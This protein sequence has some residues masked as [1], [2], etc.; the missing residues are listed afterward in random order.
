MLIKIYQ[1]EDI[2]VDTDIFDNT[3]SIKNKIALKLDTLPKYIF[4]HGTK[5]LNLKDIINKDDVKEIAVLLSNKDG[6]DFEKGLNDSFLFLEN[7]DLNSDYESGYLYLSSIREKV[8]TLLSEK[9]LDNYAEVRDEY[10][11]SLLKDS[12]K[13][14]FPSYWSDKKLENYLKI[15]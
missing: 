14:I 6:E 3:S 10:H 2:H 4:K 12:Y 5:W 15:Y 8:V 1:N 9:L 11:I 7:L 13:D